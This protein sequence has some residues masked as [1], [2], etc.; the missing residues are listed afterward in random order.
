MLRRVINTFFHNP[1]VDFGAALASRLALLY[2]ASL[3]SQQDRKISANR[4]ANILE[5]LYTE[6][7]MYRQM[8]KPGYLG[9]TRLSHAFKWKMIELGYSK[10][11]IDMATEGLV[12]YLH[13]PVGTKAPAKKSNKQD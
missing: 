13:K 6:A 8:H 12:V 10:E 4:L 5:G 11:F 2:P 3:D 9:L 7:Q 1:H